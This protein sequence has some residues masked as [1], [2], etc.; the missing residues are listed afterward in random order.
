L[1]VFCFFLSFVVLGVL[2]FRP[3]LCKLVFLVFAV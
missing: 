2:G 1:L 3:G